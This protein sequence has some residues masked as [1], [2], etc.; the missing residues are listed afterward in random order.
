MR[1][2]VT[3]LKNCN[4]GGNKNKHGV[5]KKHLKCDIEDVYCLA[6]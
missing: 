4:P 2:G 3:K 5:T 6:N 1:N